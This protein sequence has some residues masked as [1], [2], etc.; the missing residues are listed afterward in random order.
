M[1]GDIGHTNIR[2]ARQRM[3]GRDNEI[4]RVVPYLHCPDRLGSLR[5]Q[6]DD[7]QFG[8]AMQHF[9]VGDFRIE[10]TNIQADLRISAGERA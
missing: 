7:R 2:L 10:K 6:G 5:R 3:L 8:A 1:A 4:Q 9:V